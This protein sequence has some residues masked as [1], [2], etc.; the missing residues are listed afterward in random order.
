MPEYKISVQNLP[1]FSFLVQAQETLVQAA[2]RQGISFPVSCENG[3][4]G[5]CKG[6]LISGKTTYGNK[7]IYG[8][9]SEE[10]AENQILFCSAMPEEDCVVEHPGIEIPPQH[11]DQIL[12]VKA[13]QVLSDYVTE[14]S[15]ETENPWIYKPGQYLNIEIPS[16]EKMKLPFSIANA[17][18]TSL[19]KLHFQILA[20]Q[21]N[22]ELLLQ[23]L[24]ADQL[25]AEGPQGQAYLRNSSRPL[26]LVAGGSGFAPFSAILEHLFQTASSREIFLYWGGRKPEF[27]YAH[28]KLLS[29]Q[30]TFPRLHYTPVISEPSETAWFGRCGLVHH[31]VLE[32]HPNLS[33]F[34]AYLAG[35]YE[36]VKV[37]KETFIQQG[38]SPRLVFSDMT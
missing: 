13:R 4:C 26:L 12:K 10:Q 9:S 24:K 19:L 30:K 29:L 20:A 11:Y 31:A 2:E 23:C 25:H 1:G 35:P 32:D 38:L 7:E 3:L 8:L 37:A 6:Q 22:R 36:M 15:L 33:A 34:E 28:E 14:L 17:P 21:K 5:T 27:L 16:S 18:G